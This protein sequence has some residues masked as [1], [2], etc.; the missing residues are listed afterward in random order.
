M[1]WGVRNKLKKL[2]TTDEIV[3]DRCHGEDDD[4]PNLLFAAA[5]FYEYT[6]SRNLV[7]N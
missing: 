1:R 4:S 2:N 3:N 7:L 6:K 5:N